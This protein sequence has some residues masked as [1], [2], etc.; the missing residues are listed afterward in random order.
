MGRKR[1]IDRDGILDAAEEL[2]REQGAAHLSLDAVARRAGIS[3][4]G[5]MYNFPSKDALIAAI[6]ERDLGRFE[7]L[8]AE[9]AERIGEKP[10]AT[11]LARIEAT[12]EESPE[13]LAKGACLTA[14][15]A[16]TPE[17]LGPIQKAYGDEMLR[18][19]PETDGGRRARLA[20]IAVEGAFLL[21]GLGLMELSEDEWRLIF[22]DIRALVPDA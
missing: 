17:H 9:K 14:T 16:Q 1:T 2:T 4:G 19:A 8:L 22:A 12:E 21:R 10:Y 3:K 20:M 5:L 18:Y 6:T 11:L 13:T 15:L 7:S